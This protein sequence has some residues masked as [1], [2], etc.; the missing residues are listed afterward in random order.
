MLLDVSKGIVP[1]GG[2]PAVP[3]ANHW[4]AQP[5]RVS[6][7]FFQTVGF[8]ADIALAKDILLITANRENILSS[9]SDRKAAGSFAE[10]TSDGVS[11][12][13]WHKDLLISLS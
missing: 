3:P 1:T 12:R 8:G 11:V 2:K 13:R 6:V 7:Q 4:C 9:G 5:I 10:W